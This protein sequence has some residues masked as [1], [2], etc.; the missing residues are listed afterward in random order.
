MK[1]YETNLLEGKNTENEKLIE[2][3]R[4]NLFVW[5][6]LFLENELDK[7]QAKLNK[8]ISEDVRDF[9]DE[10]YKYQINARRNPFSF[11]FSEYS[12]SK[13]PIRDT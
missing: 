1:N 7:T 10:P 8:T 9:Y 5:T 2:E 11:L 4:E 13:S 3:N 6:S 12:S